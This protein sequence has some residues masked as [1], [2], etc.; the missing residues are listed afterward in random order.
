MKKLKLN[1]SQFE[2]AEVL[3]REQLK[4]VI[5]GDD[6]SDAGNDCNVYCG[7]GA[8]HTCNSKGKCPDCSDAGNGKGSGK[9][10]DKMCSS[11]GN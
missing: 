6:G 5:G 4:K 8:G 10:E 11:K 1:L 9:G 3:S 2:G 7:D